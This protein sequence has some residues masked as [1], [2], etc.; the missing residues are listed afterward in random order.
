[1]FDQ[2]IND[3]LYLKNVS[4]RTVEYYRD[5]ER[6]LGTTPLT[7]RGLTALFIALRQ[8]GMK[9]TSV[10]CY[11][12]GINAYLKWAGLPLKVAKLK[13]ARLV[14]PTY[15]DDDLGRLITFKAHGWYERRLHVVLM[16]IDCGARIRAGERR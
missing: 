2:F 5:C 7:E 6:I 8:R 16:L 11:I 4:P 9:V 3:R 15:S 12:R 1:M 10:N 14:L 13:E